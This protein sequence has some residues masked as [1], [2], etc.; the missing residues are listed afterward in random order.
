MAKSNTSESVVLGYLGNTGR[1]TAPHL[2]LGAEVR[3]PGEK[4][5]TRIDPGTIKSQLAN[6]GTVGAD[7]KF[8][9]LTVQSA[10]GQFTWNNDFQLTSGFRT[11][12][13]PNHQG[14]DIVGSA[15]PTQGLPWHVRRAPNVIGFGPGIDDPAGYGNNAYVTTRGDDGSEY[16]FTKAH[17]DQNPNTWTNPNFGQTDSTQTAAAS[18]PTPAQTPAQASQKIDGRTIVNLAF[19]L[20]KK[21]DDEENNFLSKYINQMIASTIAPQDFTKLANSIPNYYG[22]IG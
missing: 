5:F 15:F 14:V 18:T 20:G 7:G 10:P 16:R 22:D 8:I 2:H 21:E 4:D 19:N 11:S 6:F 17:L 1:S 13:R 9:P 3:R 12:N